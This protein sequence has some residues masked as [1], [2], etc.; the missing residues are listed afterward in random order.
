MHC[1]S[2]EDF[3]L[4][5]FVAS[6]L[7][8]YYGNGYVDYHFRNKHSWRTCLF[9]FNDA[10]HNNFVLFYLLFL[11]L[12]QFHLFSCFVFMLLLLL[13]FVQAFSLKEMWDEYHDARTFYAHSKTSD[14]KPSLWNC[15]CMCVLFSKCLFNNFFLLQNNMKIIK[16]K[17]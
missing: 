5:L 2:H 14:L 9:N 10:K 4:F 8:N 17:K 12:F 16:K 11:L 15:V 7:I 1:F 6:F 13:L 3:C